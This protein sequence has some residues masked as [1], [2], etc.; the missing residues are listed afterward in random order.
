MTTNQEQWQK[1]RQFGTPET[2]AA[3]DARLVELRDRLLTANGYDYSKDIQPWVGS[4]ITVAFLSSSGPSPSS[5]TL[6][7]SE[8]PLVMVV[9][10]ANPL[11]AKQLLDQQESQETWVERSYKGIEIKETPKTADELYSTAVL[12]T[13]YLVVTNNSQATNRVI[14]T[15]QQLNPSLGS[16]PGYREALSQI[17]NSQPFARMYVNLPQA[18]AIASANAAKPIPPDKLAEVQQN[19]GLAATVML[20]PEGILFR[21]ISWLHPQSEK[22]RVVENNAQMMPELWPA[23]TMLTISG[24]T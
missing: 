21:G 22:L 14:D 1:L 5:S 8:K 10:V 2:Q 20:Q 16:T 19:Q 13:R 11:L 3:F 17:Q 7:Q 9:P 12:S 15:Y 6:T 4:E 18:A 24:A 23:D